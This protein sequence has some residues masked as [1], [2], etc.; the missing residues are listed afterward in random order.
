[1]I[2]FSNDVQRDAVSNALADH[3]AKLSFHDNSLVCTLTESVKGCRTLVKTW[4]DTALKALRS[5]LRLIDV[6]VRPIDQSE[7][8]QILAALEEVDIPDP[9]QVAV[10][11]PKDSSSVVLVGIESEAK[12][13]WSVMDKV[14]TDTEN[15]IKENRSLVEETKDLKF[16]W[17]I[18]YLRI[19]FIDKMKRQY[20][21]LEI[22]LI[23][24][25]AHVFFKGR[26]EEVTQ[27]QL[28]MFQELQSVQETRRKLGTEKANLLCKEEV[29]E[30]INKQIRGQ[31]RGCIWDV[32]KDE[33]L[34]FHD[35]NRDMTVTQ[36]IIDDFLT[37]I[38]MPLD[39]TKTGILESKIWREAEKQ[40]LRKCKDCIEINYNKKDNILEVVTIEDF[41]SIV[42]DELDAFFEKNAVY[43]ETFKCDPSV[44]KYIHTYKKNDFKG[45][46]VKAIDCRP[47]TIILKGTR[48][49]IE[50]GKH[51]LNGIKRNISSKEDVLKQPGIHSYFASEEGKNCIQRAEKSIPCIIELQGGSR[52]TGERKEVRQSNVAFSKPTKCAETR[53][54]S[55]PVIEVYGGDMTELKVDVLVNASNNKLEH[56][57]GLAKV[58]V[59]KGKYT[60]LPL[61]QPY[62]KIFCMVQGSALYFVLTCRIVF[63]FFSR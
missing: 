33:L 49:E 48:A 20:P 39:S 15:K 9:D 56:A 62:C 59:R 11:V 21:D 52:P 31:H 16:S 29:K 2:L 34:F 5:H 7:R 53:L 27:A 46:D 50:A 32:Q 51:F 42:S 26:K 37:T 30:R 22:S 3:Y 63:P 25:K 45:P 17:K 18:L 36:S 23:E 54:S 44:R 24:K 13:V 35:D 12:T 43:E 10:Y 61:F 1:M 4:R 19:K 40:L 41:E 8:R 38:S 58:I 6:R 55:G 28:E 14:I 47:D 60:L 57:G